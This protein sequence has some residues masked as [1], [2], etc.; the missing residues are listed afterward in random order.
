MI[1]SAFLLCFLFHFILTGAQPRETENVIIVTLDGFRWREVFNGADQKILRKEG[2]VRDTSVMSRFN[3]PTA[4]ERRKKLLPFFWNVIGRQGQLYGN[5]KYGNRMKLQNMN[6]YSYAGYSEMFVGFAD[7]RVRSNK[8]APNPNYPVL[9]TLNKHKNFA[10]EV[11]AFSTWSVMPFIL[12]SEKSGIPVNSGD[13]KAVGPDLTENERILNFVT[14]E[15]KNP[16]GDRYDN[17]TFQYAL[18]YM[19]R[20]RPRVIFIS[21]DETDEHGHGGRYD[22]YLKSAHRADRMIANLWA[23]VQ[24]QDDYR[25]KTTLLIGTDHGRGKSPKGWK[26]HAILFR[27]SA[28]VWLAVIGP[29]TPS[30]GEMKGR[31]RLCQNQIAQSIA[32][33]LGVPYNQ[34]SKTGAPIGSIFRNPQL[35]EEPVMS[36]GGSGQ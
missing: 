33:L 14:T 31:M 2:Y 19:K 12:R 21:L 8:P 24:S 4:E 29:D 27:G 11:A 23:W 5:K 32:A 28:E 30:S 25:N 18:E 6:M 22:E 26:R 15:V 7:P 16:H 9:E 10:G 17:F 1:R 35:Q 3:A 34:V 36:L 13:D 20:K